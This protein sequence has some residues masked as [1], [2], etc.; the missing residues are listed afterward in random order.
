[1]RHRLIF[2]VPRSVADAVFNLDLHLRLQYQYTER[3]GA[4]AL[5]VLTFLSVAAV[6]IP[7]A[8]LF[9]QAP[10]TLVGLLFTQ[11]LLA[12]VLL[13]QVV[14][15]NMVDQEVDGTYYY[16]TDGRA[17][18]PVG[19]IAL[20]SLLLTATAL[21]LLGNG[22]ANCQN[23]NYDV[24]AFANWVCSPSCPPIVFNTT[25]CTINATTLYRTPSLPRTFCGINSVR[26]TRP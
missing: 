24:T 16:M 1:M 4:I 10:W 26:T 5:V 20:V 3:G 23:G 11:A 6:C 18:M 15:R 2:H 19:V 25:Q 14:L 12:G 8:F 17:Y 7:A 9:K 21:A 13:M 22:F